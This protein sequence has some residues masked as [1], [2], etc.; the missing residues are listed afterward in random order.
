MST[1][2]SQAD[3]L[4]IMIVTVAFCLVA[5]TI[6]HRTSPSRSYALI[7]A[8]LI[9][10][11]L[12]LFVLN[13]LDAPLPTSMAPSDDRAYPSDA[14]HH[15]TWRLLLITGGVFLGFAVSAYWVNR[16]RQLWFPVALK[17]LAILVL[18][19]ALN[20]VFPKATPRRLI[21]FEA[22]IA[23]SQNLQELVNG[24]ALVAVLSILGLLL[25]SYL[26]GR[27]RTGAGLE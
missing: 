13:W 6:C 20:Q 17:T 21:D 12:G 2:T 9:A 19:P 25:L 16:T 26:F 23:Q 10:P 15:V 3:A 18:I 7:G 27:R 5:Y 24:A 11:T 1:N 22:T 8:S 4:N 14:F